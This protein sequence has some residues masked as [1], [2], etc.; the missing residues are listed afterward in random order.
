MCGAA[1]QGPILDVATIASLP[2]DTLLC[3]GPGPTA[4]APSR[5]A[6]DFD[7]VLRSVPFLPN[8]LLMSH[9]A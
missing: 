6:T 4:G 5:A 8:R 1:H 2:A 7:I 3:L 9:L